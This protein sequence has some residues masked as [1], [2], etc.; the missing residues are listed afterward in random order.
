MHKIKV[1]YIFSFFKKK[2]Y[3]IF[4]IIY[5]KKLQTFLFFFNNSKKT[6]TKKWKINPKRTSSY[7]M[8]NELVAQM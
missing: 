4:I 2:Y 5:L 1:K 6:E 7:K 8:I 3:I